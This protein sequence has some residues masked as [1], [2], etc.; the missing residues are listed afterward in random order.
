MRKW[1]LLLALGTMFMFPSLT[2]AKND[3]AITSLEVNL[4][5]E[6]DRPE[7]LVIE[8]I[9]LS[10]D[11]SLPAT[12]ELRVPAA[13]EAPHVVAVGPSPDSVTDQ[14]VLFT[15]KKEGDWLVV[16]IE[17]G[18]PAIQFEYYDPGLKKVGDLRSYVYEWS[19]D[20]DVA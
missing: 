4:W 15:T 17:A 18:G 19:S 10:P 14:G 16:S 1:V 11:T 6:Y 20:Y 8:Y 2:F 7:V 5:P 9:L 13:V 3:I 12:V